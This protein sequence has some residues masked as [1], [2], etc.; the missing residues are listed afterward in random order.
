MRRAGPRLQPPRAPCW[1][2]PSTP[3]PLASWRCPVALDARAIAIDGETVQCQTDQRPSSVRAAGGG[4]FTGVPRLCRQ[5][6]VRVQRGRLGRGV[7]AAVRPGLQPATGSRPDAGAVG[8]PRL[9]ERAVCTGHR[10]GRSRV[11]RPGAA[12]LP[13]W[14]PAGRGGVDGPDPTDEG[15]AS[16]AAAPVAPARARRRSGQAVHAGDARCAAARP[17]DQR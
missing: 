12:A 13:A 5:R 15:A 2:S 3:P 9:R 17:Q 7:G 11:G 8:S 6:A 1:L 4:L 10:G 16:G 14:S